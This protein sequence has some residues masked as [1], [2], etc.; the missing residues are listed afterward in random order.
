MD[1]AISGAAAALRGGLDP[2]AAARSQPR[3]MRGAVRERLRAA[4]RDAHAGLDGH[5]TMQA[6]L[7]GHSGRHGYRSLLVS[8]ARLYDALETAIGK[9]SAYLPPDYDWAA[10][11]K[12]PWLEQDLAYLGADGAPQHARDFAPLPAI[13]SRAKMLGVLYP[14]EGSTL[15]GLTIGKRLAHALGIDATSG[16]RFF[17]GYGSSTAARWAET[18]AVIETIADDDAAQEAAAGAAIRI[19]HCFACALDAAAPAP[20]HAD[21]TMRGAR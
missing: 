14:L 17:H 1:A 16:A 7:A 12:L 10:R 13:D 11:R 6:L 9:A 8:Y 5:P 19:F 4:T 15:G 2:R 20:P 21:A 18:C 3:A